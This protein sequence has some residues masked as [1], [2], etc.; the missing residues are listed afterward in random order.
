MFGISDAP[1]E[2]PKLQLAKRSVPVEPTGAESTN[3]AI[4][5]GAKPVDTTRKEREI[6]EKLQ[7][8][9]TEEKSRSRTTSER[10]GGD[11]SGV[12]N[13]GGK[14]DQGP[15]KKSSIFGDAKPVDSSK[16]EREIEEKLKHVDI[17]DDKK[18]QPRNSGPRIHS[19]SKPDHKKNNNPNR[20][21]HDDKRS[22][23]SPPPMKKMEDAKPPVSYFFFFL[24]K[25]K[26]LPSKH[27]FNDSLPS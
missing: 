10:S 23:R 11:D 2:R 25:K 14:A 13:D 27:H 7:L 15:P 3:S 1:R 21:G 18:Q 9:K 4:F 20:D 19:D 5:G 6:E 26:L 16:R 12:E 22:P 24:Q 8:Q 17:D